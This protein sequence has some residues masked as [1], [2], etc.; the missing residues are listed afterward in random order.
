MKLKV[1]G[2]EVTTH[3]TLC[4][5]FNPNLISYGSVELAVLCRSL[6]DYCCIHM[7]N[8]LVDEGRAHFSIIL[9]AYLFLSQSGRPA[10]VPLKY[11]SRFYSL[12]F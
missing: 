2:T 1:Q 5:L 9:L 7:L 4:F 3:P 8:V 6:N 10:C 12:M 11:P